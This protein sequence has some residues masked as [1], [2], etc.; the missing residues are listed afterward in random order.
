VAAANPAATRRMQP[1][2]ERKVRAKPDQ[3]ARAGRGT[4]HQHHQPPHPAQLTDRNRATPRT[5]VLQTKITTADAQAKLRRFPQGPNPGPSS[6]IAW[7]LCPR[8]PAPARAPTASLAD[9]GSP[10]GIDLNPGGQALRVLT[11][12]LLAAAVLVGLGA[13]DPDPDPGRGREILDLERA[14]GF[15]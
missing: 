6:A 10:L 13:R 15:G 1:G 5:R 7:S 4:R 9:A 2:D 11:R 3:I 14:H 12:E 8:P